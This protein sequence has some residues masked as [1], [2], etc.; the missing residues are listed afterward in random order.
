MFFTCGFLQMFLTKYD[1][2]D[3]IVIFPMQAGCYLVWMF[4][5]QEKETSRH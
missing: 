3:D 5:V 4:Y 1:D 2:D